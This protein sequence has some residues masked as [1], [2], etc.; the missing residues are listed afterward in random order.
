MRGKNGKVYLGLLLLTEGAGALVGWRTGAAVALFQATARQPPLS[1]PG[2]AFPAVWTALYALMAAGAGR[3]WTA[4]R[5][6]ERTLGL[7]LFF[8]QLGVNLLWPVVFFSLGWFGAALLWL[9]ALWALALWMMAAFERVDPL[10]AWLQ[11]PYLLWLTFAAY[12]NFGVWLL[13]SLPR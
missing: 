5:S 7:R 8:V 10:A 12:L 6:P 4:E 13:N 9:A 1:P 11:A 2:W 3:L